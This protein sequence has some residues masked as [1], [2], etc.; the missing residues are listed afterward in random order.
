MKLKFIFQNTQRFISDNVPFSI[1]ECPEEI[2]IIWCK[3]KITRNKRLFKK[4]GNLI[5]NTQY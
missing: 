2:K 3:E 4:Q 1:I 5:T